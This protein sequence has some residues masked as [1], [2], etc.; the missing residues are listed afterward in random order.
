M[1]YVLE[2]KSDSLQVLKLA[3]DESLAKKCQLE[4]D[5]RRA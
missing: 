3:L 1:E 4:G 2:R 5:F